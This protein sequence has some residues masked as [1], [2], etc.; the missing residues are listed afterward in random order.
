M[1]TGPEDAKS[2][3]GEEIKG[4]AKK[5]IG[6]V[7]GDERMER[8]GQAQQDKADAHR[9]AAKAEAEAEKERAEAKMHEAE[10]RAH[11]D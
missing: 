4:S 3:I 2:G 7:T 9:D 11:Q 10:Q 5:V 6:S 1:G 8:E